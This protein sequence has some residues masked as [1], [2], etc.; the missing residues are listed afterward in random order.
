MHPKPPQRAQKRSHPFV[1]LYL[2]IFARGVFT[3]DGENVSVMSLDT[4]CMDFEQVLL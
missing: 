4:V 2:E 1:D 3:I